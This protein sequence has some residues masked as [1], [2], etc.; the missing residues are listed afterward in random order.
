MGGRRS[1]WN[2]R[3]GLLTRSLLSNGLPEKEKEE[4]Q[5]RDGAAGLPAKYKP[6]QEGTSGVA[7][8]ALV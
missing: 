2:Q 1:W 8:S 3:K 6:T 7:S 5:Q 4:H